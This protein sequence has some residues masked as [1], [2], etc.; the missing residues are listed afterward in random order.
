MNRFYLSVNVCPPCPYMVISV[1][2]EQVLSVRNSEFCS[3]RQFYSQTILYSDSPLHFEPRFDFWSGGNRFQWMALCVSRPYKVTS[4]QNEQAFSKT[5]FPLPYVHIWS[6]QAR[7]NRFSCPVRAKYQSRMN[8]CRNVCPMS[9]YGH[10]SSERIGFICPV[11][12]E[13]VCGV[14]PGQ[15]NGYF[16]DWSSF[17]C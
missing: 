4:V 3:S 8:R 17:T 1:Q 6:V 11:H 15:M 10:F 9:I 13:Y 16:E 12:L 5:E 7:M 2:N 14:P